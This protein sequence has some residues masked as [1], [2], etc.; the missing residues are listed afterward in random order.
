MKPW[1]IAVRAKTEDSVELVVYDIIGKG[2]FG[3][4]ISAQDVLNLL[5]ANPKAKTINLRVNSV[6]GLVEDAKAM[7]NLLGE[8]AAAGVDVVAWVDGLAASSAAYL[9]TAAT[10]VVMPANAFMMLHGVRATVRGTASDVE[11]AAEHMR[12]TNEQLV[13]GYA[14]ASER[15]GKKKTKVD[16]LAAFAKGDLYLTADEAIEWGLADEKLEAPVKMAASLADLSAFEEQRLG[17][18]PEAL[19]AAPY[20]QLTAT[21]APAVPQPKTPPSPEG[22]EQLPQENLGEETENMAFSKTTLTLLN[23]AEEADEAAVNAAISKLK[24]QSKLGADLETLVGASGPAALGAVRALKTANEANA[25]LGSKVA[26]L[27]IVN[28][29]KDFEQARDQGLKDRKLTPATAKLYTDR[30]EDCLKDE[31]S[32]ADERAENAAAVGEDLKGFLAVAPRVVSVNFA[33]PATGGSGAGAM[34]HNN[35]SFE[36]MTGLERKTLKDENPELYASMREDA[37]ARR[38]I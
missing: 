30:F 4:G 6:G 8:R 25:E 24:G 37:L 26:Q 16:Y 28:A 38:A 32:S 31:A 11:D 27:Q 21:A 34:Q 19:R 2:F 18:T 20:V 1:N 17:A 7:V 12:R 29:R 36:A 23:L 9:L 35:K 14:A 5:R 3:E 13:E 15:R 33:Q 10:R 22:P